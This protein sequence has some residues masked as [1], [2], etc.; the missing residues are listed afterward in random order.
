MAY[1]AGNAVIEFG[2]TTIA[3]PLSVTA[4]DWVALAVF[5]LSTSATL[6]SVTDSQGN[7]WTIVHNPTTLTGNGRGALAYVK[8]A[9]TGTL[10]ITATFSA[11]IVGVTIAAGF[12]GRDSTSAF[13]G[14]NAT[15]QTGVA[16]STDAISSGA[17]VTTAAGD[18]VFAA[19]CDL[20][21][22]AAISA[23]TGW[24]N[25][26]TSDFWASESQVQGGAGS[27]TATFT[28]STTSQSVITFIVALKASGG[29][30]GGTKSPPFLPNPIQH[31]LV[32]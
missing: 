17:I 31:L 22:N 14:S 30:G 18:D 23:G 3:N 10:T 19:T 26:V 5:W 8:A 32:R 25:R 12:S 11:S 29:G 21:V 1:T 24:T 28:P 9:S 27:I 2:S 6:S 15:T 16:N 13:D 20:N 7:T 4:G